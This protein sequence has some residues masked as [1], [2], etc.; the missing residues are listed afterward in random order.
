MPL[1][2]RASRCQGMG[3]NAR[4]NCRVLDIPGMASTK[5]NRDCFQFDHAGVD[6]LHPGQLPL[7]TSTRTTGARSMLPSR[8][9]FPV[10]QI[11]S[12]S[13]CVARA[14]STQ[15]MLPSMER[16]CRAFSRDSQ[17]PDAMALNGRLGGAPKRLCPRIS[18]AFWRA[19]ERMMGTSRQ[20]VTGAG[21]ALVGDSRL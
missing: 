7:C 18:H 2:C 14:K 15:P 10:R 17:A 11:D 8:G 16:A 5:G 19:A 20:S 9:E 12:L 4:R 6:R 3:P 13:R 1:T 21:G